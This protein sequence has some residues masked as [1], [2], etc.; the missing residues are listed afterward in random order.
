MS[1][2]LAHLIAAREDQADS[3][4]AGPVLGTV[5]NNKDKD[6]LNRVQVKLPWIGNGEEGP[7]A[8]VV[9]PMAGNNRGLYFLPDPGDEVLVLFDRGDVRFPYVIGALWNGK[10]KAPANNDDGSNNLRIIRSRSGHVVSFNDEPGKEAFTIV[11]A[12][13]KNS[14]LID[15][16]KN[17]ITIT[18][19][20]DIALAAPNGKVTISAKTIDIKASSDGTF[21]SGG[22]MTVHATDDLAVQGKTVNI[23]C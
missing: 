21:T 10:D 4:A 20:K 12:S 11:D 8:R 5:T 15:T 19:D 13:G 7:W 14:I 1:R 2:H 22:K 23:N 17:A 9:M 6:G 16:A 3:V 18:S